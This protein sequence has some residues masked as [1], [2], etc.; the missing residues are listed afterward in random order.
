MELPG[1]KKWMRFPELI[2]GGGKYRGG[3][4]GWEHEGSG[5]LRWGWEGV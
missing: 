4:E 1:K 2:E 5:W 3:E